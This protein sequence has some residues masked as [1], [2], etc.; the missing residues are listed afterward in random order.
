MKCPYCQSLIKNKKPAHTVIA[1]FGGVTNMS[2][3]TGINKQAL[4]RWTYKREKN[5]GTGGII[6]AKHHANILRV[7]KKNGIEISESDLV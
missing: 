6:P 5:A 2:K 1:K 7:A 3:L 4:Y